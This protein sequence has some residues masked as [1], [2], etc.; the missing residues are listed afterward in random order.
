ME[1]NGKQPVLII[2]SDGTMQQ[3][4]SV[5]IAFIEQ[6]ARSIGDYAQRLK[7]QAIINPPEARPTSEEE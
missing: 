3:V 7:Q 4:A 5:N 2:Y 6:M 1:T